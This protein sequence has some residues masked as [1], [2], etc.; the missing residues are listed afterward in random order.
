MVNI[1]ITGTRHGM[2]IDQWAAFGDVVGQH[3]DFN[4][5]HEFHD[6]DCQG[7]DS[8]A[9]STIASLKKMG[10]PITTHSHPSRGQNTENWRAYSDHDV[11]HESLPPLVRNRVMVDVADLCIAAPR[12]YDEVVKGSGT[13][14][15]IR[16]ARSK[17]KH[18]IIIWPD[19]TR[20]EENKKK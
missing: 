2:T 1:M 9:L 16:Y 15:T 18:L 11:T 17:K 20:S 3:L 14:A 8:Q 19:G 10:A 13:W 7:A 5:E 4:Q 12:E 6:G